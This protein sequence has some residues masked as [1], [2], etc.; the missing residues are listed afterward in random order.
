M[1]IPKRHAL[2]FLSMIQRQGMLILPRSDL[3]SKKEI[4]NHIIEVLSFGLLSP[5]KGIEN[6]ISALPRILKKHPNAVYIILGVT[7]PHVVRNEGETYRLSLQWLAHEKHVESNVIFYNRFVSTE[8]LIEFIGAA[9]I[10]ITPY[11]NS[12]QRHTMRKRAYLYGRSMIWLCCQIIRILNTIQLWLYR[13]LSAI[14]LDSK[15]DLS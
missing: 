13:F 10:Y 6:V 12:A 15:T 8:E 7:H 1:Y 3:N 9:D 14:N 4:L 2:Q 5:N 11:L